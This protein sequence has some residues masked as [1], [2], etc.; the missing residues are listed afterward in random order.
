MQNWPI[1]LIFSVFIL[2]CTASN[3]SRPIDERLLW[4]D[5]YGGSGTKYSVT[6]NKKRMDTRFAG[7]QRPICTWQ[8]PYIH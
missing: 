5:W 8:G 3:S 6:G 1:F 2:S 4:G 7:W